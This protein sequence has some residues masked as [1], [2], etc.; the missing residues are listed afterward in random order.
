VQSLWHWLLRCCCCDQDRPAA[1]RQRNPSRPPR[2]RLQPSRSHPLLRCDP[3]PLRVRT[4]LPRRP[5]R[6]VPIEAARPGH[7]PQGAA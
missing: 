3:Q 7:L 2:R 5:H 6:P 1:S 4:C